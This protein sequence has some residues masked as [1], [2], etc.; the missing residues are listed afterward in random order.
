MRVPPTSENIV[1][2]TIDIGEAL[3]PIWQAFHG[4]G[5]QVYVSCKDGGRIQRCE[6][7]N[8][9]RGMKRGKKKGKRGGREAAKFLFASTDQ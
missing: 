6:E 5:V 1:A 2:A 8:S 3:R 4:P 9:E 7:A